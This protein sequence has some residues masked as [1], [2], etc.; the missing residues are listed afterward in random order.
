MKTIFKTMFIAGAVAVVAGCGSN[1][2]KAQEETAAAVV[3]EVAPT[4][5]VAQV[6]VREVPQIAT[7]TSTE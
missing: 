7:Y 1:A 2:N 4:V 6:N 3:E 5:A